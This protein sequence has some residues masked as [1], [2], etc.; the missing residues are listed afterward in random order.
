MPSVLMVVP[1][2]NEADR[3]RGEAFLDFALSRPG[4]RFLFV[5][6]GST[7]ATAK[8]LEDIAQQRP[9]RLEVLSLSENQ[10]KA[11]AVRAGVRHALEREIPAEWIGYLDAD[12]AV[13]LEE[14]AYLFQFAEL[15]QNAARLRL[16]FGSRVARGGA[17]V[18]RKWFRYYISRILATLRS[19]VLPLIIYDTQCGVKLVRRDT[20]EALFAQ[21]F[22]S[23]WLFDIELFYRLHL[24]GARAGFAAP[25]AICEVPLRAWTEVDGSRTRLADLPM[26]LRSLWRISRHY[27]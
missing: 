6:D 16:I 12:L 25:D 8:L 15:Q 1:C 21:P 10:G 13:P 4:V 11:G 20:A 9:D 2:Y 14:L 17:Q 7:D 22:V 5:N 27:R 3:L 18:K 19:Q 26:Y 23:Q 24:E